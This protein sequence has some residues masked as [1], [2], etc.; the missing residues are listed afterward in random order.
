MEFTEKLA[1]SQSDSGILPL[2]DFKRLG[3]ASRTLAAFHDIADQDRQSTFKSLSRIAHVAALSISTVQRHIARLIETGHITALGRQKPR[4]RRMARRT[5]TYRLTQPLT[6]ETAYLPLPKSDRHLPWSQALVL[7]YLTR[8]TG[9]KG[10][11]AATARSI[12]SETGLSMRAVQAAL[13]ALPHGRGERCKNDHRPYAKM[14]FAVNPNIQELNSETTSS[15]QASVLRAKTGPPASAVKVVFSDQLP[16]P[17]PTPPQAPDFANI[18]TEDLRTPAGRRALFSDA[19]AR[20]VI[21]DTHENR[22]HFQACCVTSLDK[23]KPGAYLRTMVVNRWTPAAKPKPTRKPKFS[24]TTRQ[25]RH[26]LGHVERAQIA[27]PAAAV[28]LVEHRLGGQS[29][30]A[31]LQIAAESVH[32]MRVASNP[33]AMFATNVCRQR[34][35]A[36]LDDED[37]VR[38][39]QRSAIAY[40]KPKL[41]SDPVPISEILNLLPL[42]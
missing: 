38:R 26:N 2:V 19:V 23:S 5:Q 36:T 34:W 13:V 41:N 12:A 6:P 17:S 16:P 9:P 4:G 35:F 33:A 25:P 3:P 27:D 28:A 22:L 42:P 8:W 10:P 29:E 7:A 37:E 39:R 24:T 31:R 30:H 32:A 20:G 14:T 1:E 15:Q 11:P 40:E 18:Q 21:D